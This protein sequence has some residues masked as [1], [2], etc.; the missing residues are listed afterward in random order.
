M[1]LDVYRKKIEKSMEVETYLYHSRA[2][3]GPM[4]WTQMSMDENLIEVWG[5]E[6]Y[7]YHSKAIRRPML[8][9]CM[10]MDES[11]TSMETTL[12]LGTEG[13]AMD[14]AVDRSLK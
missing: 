6:T 8:W 1:D 5:G 12:L 13:V 7:L 3:R 14:P 4:L 11:T 10:S 2:I 9:T